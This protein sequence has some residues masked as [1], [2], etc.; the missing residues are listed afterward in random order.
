[1]PTD[2]PAPVNIIGAP[3]IATTLHPYNDDGNWWK[4]GSPFTDGYPNAGGTGSLL[5]QDRKLPSGCQAATL[6]WRTQCTQGAPLNAPLDVT[7]PLP[8]AHACMVFRV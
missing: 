3:L 8:H 5:I 7:C 4:M 6:S 1:M 2:P